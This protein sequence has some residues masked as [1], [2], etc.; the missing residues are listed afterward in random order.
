MV[1]QLIHWTLKSESDWQSMVTSID[2]ISDELVASVGDRDVLAMMAAKEELWTNLLRKTLKTALSEELVDTIGHKLLAI[3][4]ELIVTLAAN[5][6][7]SLETTVDM[8][9]GHS[10]FKDILIDHKWMDSHI[11]YQLICILS[12]VYEKDS[13]L[14]NDLNGNKDMISLILSAY[15]LSLN[16]CDQKLLKLLSYMETSGHNLHRYVPFLWGMNGAIHYSIKNKQKETLL[17][18]PKMEQI[19]SSINENQL[20]YTLNNFPIDLPLNPIQ[21]VDVTDGYLLTDP[22][23]LLPLLY[24]MLSNQS[25]VK[26][27]KF[28]SYGCLSYA[29]ASLSSRDADM[30]C[31]AYC[32]LSRF[33]SHLEVASFPND[34]FLWLAIIDC[35]RSAITSDNMRIQSLISVFMVRI[36]DILLH[37]NDKLYDSVRHFLVNR[38]TID[39]NVLPEFYQNLYSPDIETQRRL[40]R[41]VISWIC[42]GLRTEDD[43]KLCLKRNVFRE[44][45]VLYDSRLTEDENQ[46]LI[47]ESLR[48]TCSHLKG[49]KVLCSENA[50]ICWLRQTIYNIK[51]QS[52]TSLIMDEMLAIIETIWLTISAESSPTNTYWM[53]NIKSRLEVTSG[54]TDDILAPQKHQDIHKLESTAN[55]TSPEYP[56]YNNS[57][58][59]KI[60]LSEPTPQEFDGPIED[61]DYE[62]QE[63]KTVYR[64]SY[65]YTYSEPSTQM[66]A[67]MKRYPQPYYLPSDQ[68]ESYSPKPMASSIMENQIK[69]HPVYANL[70]WRK[71]IYPYPSY[72]TQPSNQ[73]FIISDNFGNN[74]EGLQSDESIVNRRFVPQNPYR[75]NQLINMTRL[76][77]EWC[78]GQR[79]STVTSWHNHFMTDMSQTTDGT[80]SPSN[81]TQK[82]TIQYIPYSVT[83]K[84]WSS[85][86]DVINDTSPQSS[87]LSPVFRDPKDTIFTSPKPVDYGFNQKKPLITT[88]STT[89]YMRQSMVKEFQKQNITDAND[90]NAHT[91]AAEV[92]SRYLK[93]NPLL[94]SPSIAIPTHRSDY[95]T[96][97]VYENL[98]QIN[99][100]SQNSP[101][102][103]SLNEIDTQSDD[104]IF[105]IQRK[106]ASGI[107]FPT[108]T[109]MSLNLFETTTPVPP[110]DSQ[111]YPHSD[112]DEEHHHEGDGHDDDEPTPPDDPDDYEDDEEIE[113]FRYPVRVTPFDTDEDHSPEREPSPPFV[114]PNIDLNPE[115]L[116]QKGC[117]TIVKEVQA[118]PVENGVKPTNSPPTDDPKTGNVRTKRNSDPNSRKFTSIVMT[119]EC[120]FPDDESAGSEQTPQALPTTI[121]SGSKQQNIYQTP[122][123]LIFDEYDE[124]FDSFKPSYPTSDLIDRLETKSSMNRKSYA[125]NPLFRRDNNEYVP[126]KEVDLDDTDFYDFEEGDIQRRPPTPKR[127]PPP[128]KP[129]KRSRHSMSSSDEYDFEDDN[130]GPTPPPKRRHNPRE[131]SSNK[132]PPLYRNDRQGKGGHRQRNGRKKPKTINKSFAF[133]RKA[134]PKEKDPNE[135]DYSVSYGRGNFQSFSD[136]YDSDRD[137]PR[138]KGKNRRQSRG[139]SDD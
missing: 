80:H 34:R 81:D 65:P 14:I 75:R 44:L 53:T 88:Q 37:P 95:N 40:Q 1:H 127:P 82:S 42:D 108:T 45:M 135:N 93:I 136:S 26:C 10:L 132:R 9:C 122:S 116:K 128:Q 85:R 50:F 58:I 73:N 22:R 12:V 76:R 43:I 51:D 69:Q 56:D 92:L 106:S 105:K 36:I 97:A 84:D 61:I 15:N 71:I 74:L 20:K 38:P 119:K 98:N 103:E 139:Y 46:I 17:K 48:R 137:G 25:V 32:V 96:T 64:E 19:L 86:L 130:F 118:I 33:H 100:M 49:A 83:Y 134:E 24:N 99:K 87:A 41:F 79:L 112:E 23:F 39:L 30:R 104:P 102:I 57:N 138:N 66:R 62:F 125:D 67:Y 111:E 21:V 133:F 2:T 131:K 27:H 31:L 129:P 109:D 47:L 101:S 55:N 70:Y 91:I 6:K 72:S 11:K 120:H 117:R 126:P 114:I 16:T 78:L 113:S 90:M 68:I 54:V 121:M 89:D 4:H 8:I 7:I 59:E 77:A 5:T 110:Q 94:S 18:E 63:P 123:P 29:I 60:D 3:I 124:D 28:V 115:S 107:S 52:N 13:K 35:V